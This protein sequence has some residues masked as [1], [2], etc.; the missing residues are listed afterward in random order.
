MRRSIIL[1]KCPG[2]GTDQV[3][4]QIP[5]IF[6]TVVL[7]MQVADARRRNSHKLQLLAINR[8]RWRNNIY[9]PTQAVRPCF[10]SVLSPVMINCPWAGFLLSLPFLFVS[11]SSAQWANDKKLPT[12]AFLANG[13]ENYIHITLSS[14]CIAPTSSFL[15]CF[16]ECAHFLI[17]HPF[18]QEMTLGEKLHT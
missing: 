9:M 14:F 8:M 16:H 18:S 10:Q 2:A 7:G 11:L 13:K 17:F 3:R 6:C 5:N 12:D 4:S 1:C 15:D